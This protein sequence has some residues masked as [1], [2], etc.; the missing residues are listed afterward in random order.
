MLVVLGHVMAA[1]SPWEEGTL[2]AVQT[3]IYSFHMP[4]FVFLAGVTAKST[5]LADRVG[6]LVVLL[7]TALPL[8]Y[9]WLGLLDLD[10][11][12]E[13]DPWAPYWVTWFL[14]AMVWWMLSVPLIERL[15][16]VM[17]AVSIAAA[18][19]GGAIP[20]YDYEFSLAR[21]LSFWPFFVVG[22]VC[23]SRLI[24]WAG[25]RSL[26]QR[27]G[28]SAAALVPIAVF[29]HYDVDKLWFYGVRG[30]EWLGVSLGEGF[31]MRALIGLSAALSTLVLLS[32]VTDRPGCL[33]RVGR[34]SLAIYL[35]HG[36]LVRLLNSLLQTG[37]GA[38]LAEAM[39]TLSAPVL[40]VICVG[41]SALI[42]ALCAVGWWDRGIRRHSE[43]V[44]SLI[45]SP[46]RRRTAEGPSR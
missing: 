27:L 34:R 19:W 28:L 14:L 42:T 24:C 6:V 39:D 9:G 21:T 45:L 13:F 17:I 25:A 7:A 5:R 46:I 12:S 11:S 33:A 30:F 37:P 41:L 43:F 3:M 22:Q 2:R 23:G 15:P 20:V 16:R 35:I 8:Y 10:P 40:L 18:L 44:V 29:F 1:L 36:F 4:A 31:S 38:E 32:W 26:P